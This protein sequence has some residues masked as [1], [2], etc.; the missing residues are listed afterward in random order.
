MKIIEHVVYAHVHRS[1][2]GV[3]QVSVLRPHA[4]DLF[5]D[6]RIK[7]Q[8]KAILVLNVFGSFNV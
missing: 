3:D 5:Q 6:K 8:L 7:S 4:L 2:I 1:E